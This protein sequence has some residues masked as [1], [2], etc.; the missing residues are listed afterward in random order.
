[1]L[2]ASIFYIGGLFGEPQI[3]ASLDS[4]RF[5]LRAYPIGDPESMTQ[6]WESLESGEL[7]G[8]QVMES[9]YYAMLV[10]TWAQNNDVQ[11]ICLGKWWIVEKP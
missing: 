5:E 2:L 10:Y 9:V 11:P 4:T 6:A 3:T 1:M 8:G 7:M